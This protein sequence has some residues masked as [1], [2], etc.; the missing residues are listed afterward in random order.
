MT[1]YCEC[2]AD[3]TCDVYDQRT[4]KARKAWRCDECRETIEV[5]EDHERIDLLFDGAWG[6]LRICQYCNHDNE[7]LRKMGFCIS[8]GE[9][10]LANAWSEAWA[11]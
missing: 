7:L 2:D 5:G 3:G 6:H 11:R 4:V 9:G 1:D 8:L 10:E